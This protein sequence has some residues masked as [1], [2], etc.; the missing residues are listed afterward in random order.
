MNANDTQ[1][2]ALHA[3]FQLMNMNG[4]ARIYRAAQELGVHDALRVGAASSAEVAEA[5]GLQEH[6]VALLLDGLCALGTVTSAAGRYSLAPVADFLSGNYRNLGD[7]YWDFLPT[8]LRTGTPL[9]RMDSTDQSEA[10]YVQQ[11]SALAWMMAPAAE[12]FAG[13]LGMGTARKSLRILDVGG[14]SGIWSLTCA[15]HDAGTTVTV[16]DWPAI[17]DIAA[18]FARRMALSDRFTA[19]PGN[20]HETDFGTGEFDLAIVA[21]VT[22]IETPEGNVNLFRRIHDALGPGGEIAIVDVIPAQ[23]E[24][25]LSAS[26]YALGLGLRTESGQVHSAAALRQY[27]AQAGFGHAVVEPILAPPFTMGAVI[28]SR[29]E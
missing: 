14:G 17:V 8:F 3:Y 12:A 16:S 15:R 23:P 24:G 25:R 11:V 20:Y 19:L 7:E 1:L 5:C 26:L 2:G 10:Q 6:P 18:G 29:G 4:A 21:N 13:L 27:L 28:A 22:H 9:A